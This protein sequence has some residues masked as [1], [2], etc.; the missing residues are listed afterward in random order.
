MGKTIAEEFVNTSSVRGRM[1]SE[2]IEIAIK[3]K[4]IKVPALSVDGKYLVVKGNWL[5]LAYVSNEQWLESEVENPNHCMKMLKGQRP[6]GIRADLFTF[7]QKLPATSPK[8]DYPLEWDSVAA[9][10]VTSFKDWWE[11]LPQETRKNVRR[12]QKRGVVVQAKKLDD[13]LIQDLYI[14]NNE[15]A[16]RQGKVFTHFGKTLEQVARDQVDYLD[17]SD[18]ICAYFENELVGVLKLVYRGDV[19]SILTFVP[20][21]SHSDKRP[22]NALIAKAV[23]LCDKKK[24]TYLT[25]GMYNYGNKRNTPLREFKIRNGFSE[26]LVPRYYIPLTAKGT[27]ALK[28]KLHRGFIGLLPHSVITVLVNA[29]AKLYTFAAPGRCSS[30][31]ERPNR[32]RQ[33]ECSTPPAGSNQRESIPDR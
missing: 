3:G 33:M 27:I 12:S 20:K 15:S 5:K 6:D 24:I 28:L 8:Y 19:A 16:V 11:R 2:I 29:R 4:W 31:S 1:A 32:I 23:E 14:L 17:R 22:A 25:Y 26:V 30:T 10:H 18:Y 21:T 13:A 7:S 9:V